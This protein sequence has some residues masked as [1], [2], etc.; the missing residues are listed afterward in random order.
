MKGGKKTHEK[1]YIY[2]DISDSCPP[3]PPADKDSK[4][5]YNQAVSK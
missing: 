4:Y 5:Y 3:P 2:L 1:Y